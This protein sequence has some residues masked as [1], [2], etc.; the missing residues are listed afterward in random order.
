M[1]IPAKA[2]EL[3]RDF[4]IIAGRYRDALGG[5][6]RSFHVYG[7]HPLFHIL[8]LDENGGFIVCDQI[9]DAGWAQL[10]ADSLNLMAAC[11]GCL[12]ASDLRA[13]FVSNYETL[14][15]PLED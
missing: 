15:Q 9:P 11:A 14:K 10:I 3:R 5:R 8:C 13:V 7:E 6:K 12:D 4:E 2:D 1:P